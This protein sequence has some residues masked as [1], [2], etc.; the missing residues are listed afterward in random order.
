MHAYAHI[1]MHSYKDRA[2]ARRERQREKERERKNY[3]RECKKWF[4]VKWNKMY[5]FCKANALLGFISI[6]L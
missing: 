2:R 6:V 1:C 4:Q 3:V 5:T